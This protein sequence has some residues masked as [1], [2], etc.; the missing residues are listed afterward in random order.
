[1]KASEQNDILCLRNSFRTLGRRFLILHY[2]LI[3]VI[4]MLE[5]IL[6]VVTVYYPRYK[7][8]ILFEGILLVGTTLSS[9]FPMRAYGNGCII[10]SRLAAA[11]L[12]QRTSPPS[13]V[14]D[15]WLNTNVL[16]FNHPTTRCVSKSY[17]DVSQ[18]KTPLPQ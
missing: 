16:L 13:Y 9:I 4:I 10:S 12:M 5:T 7:V 1:M 8:L 18:Q 15:T 6:V 3:M 2:A 14:W 11:A 17:H